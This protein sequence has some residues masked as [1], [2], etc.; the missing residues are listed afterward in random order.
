MGARACA[1][2]RVRVCA[3][4]RACAGVCVCVCARVR[5]RVRVRHCSSLPTCLCQSVCLPPS[6]PPSL[7]TFPPSLSL[8]LP[9]TR[10]LS[11]TH[12]HTSPPHLRSP[13]FSGSSS[14]L[15][16][17]YTGL[18]SRFLV[19][20]RFLIVTYQNSQN[21][22]ALVHLPNKA[23]VESTFQREREKSL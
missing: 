10:T 20:D 1:H 11:H 2:V 5:V 23:T 14:P 18:N 22:S 9:C 8:S 21:V 4:V 7:P 19:F 16:L 13:P 17:T 3:C 12:T 15:S 6:F